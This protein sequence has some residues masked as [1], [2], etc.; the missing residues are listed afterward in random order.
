MNNDKIKPKHNTTLISLAFFDQSSS[1]TMV[2][3]I[4]H[5]PGPVC[6][7]N[8][9]FQTLK[10][11]FN[12]SHLFLIC[13]FVARILNLSCKPFSISTYPTEF[14]HVFGRFPLATCSANNLQRTFVFSTFQSISTI[15]SNS[16]QVSA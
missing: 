14:K 11:S 8:N 7:I 1:I 16:K 15:Y 12:L 5:Q 6:L 9:F 10:S 4:G 13:V 3:F 2:P